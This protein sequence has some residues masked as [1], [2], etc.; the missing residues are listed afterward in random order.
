M[1]PQ[2]YPTDFCKKHRKENG[3]KETKKE[4]KMTVARLA[5]N[6]QPERDTKLKLKHYTACTNISTFFYQS[7]VDT[8]D[9]WGI[10]PCGHGTKFVLIQSGKTHK[11]I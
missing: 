4:K 11:S 8:A 5:G 7:L 6:E 2:P 9:L 10:I 1:H 3:G